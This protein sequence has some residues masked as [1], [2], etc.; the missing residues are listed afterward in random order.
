MTR[1]AIKSAESGAIYSIN[2]DNVDFYEVCVYDSESSQCA[3]KFW[4]NNRIAN[5]L[6]NKGE[7]KS[8]IHAEI[9]MCVANGEI[10]EVE[11][12]F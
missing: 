6:C 5:F 11:K 9:K 4:F 12:E 7:S 10:L 3:I 2:L 8:F 1:L